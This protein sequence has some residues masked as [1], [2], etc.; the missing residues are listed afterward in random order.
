MKNKRIL[1]AVITALSA[2]AFADTANVTVYGKVDASYDSINTGT[3]TNGTTGV[4]SNR[5]SSNT[6]YLGFKGSDDL[7]DGLSGIWQIE[8]SINVGYSA[9]TI[10]TVEIGTRNTFLGLKNDSLGTVLAGR[11]D[12]P[13]K[14]STRRFDQF[15][16]GIADNRSILGGLANVTA[17]ATAAGVKGSAAAAFDG[18]QD[19]VVAYI[20]PNLGGLTVAAA[21]V[22]LVPTQ[23]T[24]AAAQNKNATSVAAWYDANGFYGSLAYEVHSDLTVNAAGTATSENA[25]KLGLGYTLDGVFSIGAV[26]EKTKD[27]LAAAASVNGLGGNLYGHS[28][29]YLSG[30]INVGS[31]DA[32]KLAYTKANTVGNQIGTGAR[33]FSL[34][35]DH[36]LSKRTTVYVLGT[37]LINQTNAGY[38]LSGNASVGGASTLP[39]GTTLNQTVTGASPSAI[40]IGAKVTF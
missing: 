8:S 14:L 7:G 2:P 26:A 15:A 34:G 4:T 38:S 5:V 25:T 27:N 22:N 35:F 20:S 39:G 18:R 11:H 33:Q 23:N 21:H 6:T 17:S 16:D 28:A 13:Y 32:I 37:K 1:F 30:K 29:V 12:T 9:A 36:S 31:T 19:Q 3:A 24:V 40:A 10:N